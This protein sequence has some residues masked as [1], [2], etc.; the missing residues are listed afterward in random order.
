MGQ[1]LAAKSQRQWDREPSLLGPIRL[2]YARMMAIGK[3][4]ERYLADLR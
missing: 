3:R 1:R 4:G 2:A